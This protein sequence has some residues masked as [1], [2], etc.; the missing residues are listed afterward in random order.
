MP[1]GQQVRTWRTHV[2]TRSLAALIMAGLAVATV[3]G[4]VDL[5]GAG[6]LPLA[7]VAPLA[8]VVPGCAVWFWMWRPRL[9]AGPDGVDLRAAWRTRHL[10]WSEIGRCT[11]DSR[12]LV[13]TCLDGTE[14]RPPV[15]ER[16]KFAV[17]RGRHTVDRAAAYLDLR[18]RYHREGITP[19]EDAA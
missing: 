10:S 5:A 17:G 19:D 6:E 18:A 12:G 1:G 13:I 8:F 14:I 9:R 3:W 4:F 2:S 15:P 7:F 11:A 16:A